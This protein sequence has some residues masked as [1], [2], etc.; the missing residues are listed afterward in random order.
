MGHLQ[1]VVIRQ[2]NLE[3]LLAGESRM[4]LSKARDKT[5]KR[6]ERVKIRLDKLLHPL[7]GLK[8]VQPSNENIEMARQMLPIQMKAYASEI[9][10]DGNPIYDD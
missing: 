4:P 5:R 9:D 1:I 10:A 6:K 8:P 2:Y 7:A 3:W